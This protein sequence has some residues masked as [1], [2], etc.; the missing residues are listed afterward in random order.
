[1]EIEKRWLFKG[2]I[3]ELA[4]LFER[5]D[6]QKSAYLYD[7]GS[8][9]SC[10][11]RQRP[12]FKEFEGFTNQ[13]SNK[14]TVKTGK[15]LSRIEIEKEISSKEFDELV[16]GLYVM[17]MDYGFQIVGKYKLEYKRI[18]GDI[19]LEIEFDD[20]DEAKNFDLKSVLPDAEKWSDVTNDS[21]YNVICYYMRNVE[22]YDVWE[23]D[24][25]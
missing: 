24:L 10:R 9:T 15:G 1:M 12:I 14:I 3:E 8:L 4:H 25:K 2:N 11:F 23:D 7:H 21:R 18:E 22:R 20:E 6:W 5:G 13:L 19:L 17:K 16:K